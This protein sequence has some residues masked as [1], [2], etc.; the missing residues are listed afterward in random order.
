MENKEP[1]EET[2][3]ELIEEL[4]KTFKDVDLG[5]GLIRVD[6]GFGWMVIDK[7]EWNKSL[8][9]AWRRNDFVHK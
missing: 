9:D 2:L 6:T 1:T 7:E 8:L 5:N 3:K 4:G